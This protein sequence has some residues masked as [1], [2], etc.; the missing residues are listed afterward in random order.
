LRIELP[1]EEQTAWYDDVFRRI[2]AP[3]STM[4]NAR[5]IQSGKRVFIE[6]QLGRRD[7]ALVVL[8]QFASLINPPTT[9]Y[10][11]EY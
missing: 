7:E 4:P 10:E 3:V 1:S 5:V 6:V 9:A 2:L 8:E 11:E